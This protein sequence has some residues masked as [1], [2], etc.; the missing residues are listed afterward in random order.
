MC[1]CHATQTELIERLQA[2]GVPPAAASLAASSSSTGSNRNS[3]ATAVTAVSAPTEAPVA[4]LDADAVTHPV[5]K[6]PEE[7]SA[8]GTP[9]LSAI[10]PVS[11]GE[12][13]AAHV[14]F[15]DFNSSFQRISQY[16]HQIYIAAY[17]KCPLHAY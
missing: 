15:S 4:P 10:S 13:E 9:S 5:A 8:S 6:P 2:V 16:E 7:K 12:A 11:P 3:S 14:S 17:F 1:G